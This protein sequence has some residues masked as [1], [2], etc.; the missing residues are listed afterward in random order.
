MSIL[1]V[2]PRSECA[3]D[4]FGAAFKSTWQKR[5]N[6]KINQKLSI[7]IS[8]SM[9]WFLYDKDLRHERVNQNKAMI[10]LSKTGTKDIPYQIL[11]HKE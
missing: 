7:N 10:R 8:E 1:D 6:E 4:F 3:Y 9:N 5:K 11:L 2:W